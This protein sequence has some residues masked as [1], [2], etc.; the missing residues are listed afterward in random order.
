[1]TTWAQAVICVQAALA[2]VHLMKRVIAQ[3]T[4]KHIYTKYQRINTYTQ[5]IRYTL[6]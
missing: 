5:S 6:T 1:M 4:D 3:I 2:K